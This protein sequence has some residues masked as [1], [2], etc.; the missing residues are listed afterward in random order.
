MVNSFQQFN[1]LFDH[2]YFRFFFERSVLIWASIAPYDLIQS[3]LSLAGPSSVVHWNQLGI[4]CVFFA[5]HLDASSDSCLL[6]NAQIN[7]L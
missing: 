3:A 2:H 7:I 1:S 6:V 4:E 5:D